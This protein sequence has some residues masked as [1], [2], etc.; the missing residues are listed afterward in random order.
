MRGRGRQAIACWALPSYLLIG[1]P[2]DSLSG[3][4]RLDLL[5]TGAT[6][7]WAGRKITLLPLVALRY[8]VATEAEPHEY[9]K[10]PTK[11]PD[12]ADIF[13]SYTE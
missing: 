1:L 9:Q 6:R 4:S 8:T 13:W 10:G 7:D 2:R 12:S 11:I 5:R 3:N